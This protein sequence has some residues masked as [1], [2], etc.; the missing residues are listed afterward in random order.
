MSA[1]GLLNVDICICIGG[2]GWGG[3]GG[4][5]EQ[6]RFRQENGVGRVGENGVGRVCS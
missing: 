1:Y 6:A 5:R 2:G 3:V 4:G